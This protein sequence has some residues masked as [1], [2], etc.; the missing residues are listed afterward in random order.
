MI[1]LRFLPRWVDFGVAGP[2]EAK[3]L[4]GQKSSAGFGLVLAT[5]SFEK[6]STVCQAK[7]PRPRVADSSSTN[8]LSFS[9][10]RTTK[11]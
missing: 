7:K 3:N 5:P 2:E 6:I 8:A 4:A 1:A 11:R 10:A 9:S